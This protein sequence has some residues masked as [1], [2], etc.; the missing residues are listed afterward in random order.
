[1]NELIYFYT[2]IDVLLL[3]F[4]RVLFALTFLP[5]IVETKLPPAA[6]VGLSLALT[7]TVFYAMPTITLEYP[8]TVLSFF[9]LI[10]KEIIVGL[11]MSFGIM[12]FFEVYYFVGQLLSMQGGLGMSTFFDPSTSTQVPLLGK[13][14]Y[15]GFCVIF[16]VS[17]GYH[18][19]IKSLV[20]SFTYIPVG[21]SIFSENLLVTMIDAMSDFWI[22]S[23]KL[24]SPILAIIFIV[25]CGLGILARTVPQMNMFVIG[26][27]LKLIILLCMVIVTMGLLPAFNDMIIKEVV[28]LFF[29]LMQGLKPS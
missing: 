16:T 4:C 26:L 20:E 11:I 29:N 28:N 27:P 13:F 5:I 24:A 18:W 15:L 12:M 9:V 10:I 2:H 23:F 17:G 1:M 14:Y 7:A 6:R 22:I 21:K 3:I 25:D 19:F 8:P